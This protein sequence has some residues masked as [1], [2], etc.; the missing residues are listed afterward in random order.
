MRSAVLAGGTARRFGGIPKGLETAGDATLLER[1]LRV[2]RTWD[3]APTLV[4]SN[5][6]A[7][8]VTYDGP[9]VPDA[10]P[11]TGSLGGLFTALQ[12]TADTTLVTAW[13]MPFLSTGLI[14]ALS[15]ALAEFDAV[16]PGS[17]GP[18]GLEPLCAIYRPSC[19][20]SIVR[21]LDRGD[22]RMIGFHQDIR[23]HVVPLE[24]VRPFG[25]PE[26]MFFNVNTPADLTRAREILRDHP[27]SGLTHA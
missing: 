6:V 7:G 24:C 18:L 27:Q 17:D 19:L 4:V 8:R 20:P 13:D 12:H 25:D 11:G 1:V 5:A 22:Y 3:P 15:D 21:A 14:A 23:V 10:R 16:I 2:V 9:I 26:T